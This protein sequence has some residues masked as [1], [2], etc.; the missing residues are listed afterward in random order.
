MKR[1]NQGSVVMKSA[2]SAATRTKT[3]S[4]AKREFA[5]RV[6]SSGSF[7]QQKSTTATDSKSGPAA[8]QGQ[9]KK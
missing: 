4:P 3:W 5:Q 2:S 6:T 9:Q 7:T 8:H 1:D